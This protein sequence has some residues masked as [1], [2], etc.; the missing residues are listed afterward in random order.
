MSEEKY[1]REI[2]L[3]IRVNKPEYDKLLLQ[4]KATACRKFSDYLRSVIFKKPLIAFTRDRSKDEC[5][6]ELIQ[7]KKELN[8][9]GNNFNQ[10]VKRLHSIDSINSA[11]H[12]LNKQNAL[13]NSV[14]RK[15][16]EIKDYMKKI[17]ASWS[18]E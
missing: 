13:Q 11:T 17:A 5:L 2:R 8:A 15:I 9:I 12:C 1:K 10:L 4:F 14:D 18:Q 7:L 6:L 3:Q 16:T